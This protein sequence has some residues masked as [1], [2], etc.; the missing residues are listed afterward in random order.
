MPSLSWIFDLTFSIVSEDSTSSVM[1]L[2]VRVFTKICI[3][4]SGPVK[5]EVFGGEFKRGGKEKKMEVSRSEQKRADGEGK[6]GLVARTSR[7][8]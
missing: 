1:V 4:C 3:S 2:P 5:E 7:S 6:K 8:F